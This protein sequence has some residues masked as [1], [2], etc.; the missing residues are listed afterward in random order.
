MPL[1]ELKDAGQEVLRI[2]R[3]PV[4][5]AAK[6]VQNHILLLRHL[7]EIADEGVQL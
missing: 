6:P 1:E 7:L 5:T 2:T 3:V 4:D